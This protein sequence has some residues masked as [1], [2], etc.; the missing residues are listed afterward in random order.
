[1]PE[2]TAAKGHFN[3]RR[4]RLQYPKSLTPTKPRREDSI[5]SA[6]ETQ[7]SHPFPIVG[8]G[9]SAGGLEAFTELLTTLPANPGLAILFVLHLEPH[10][11]SHLAEILGRVTAMPIREAAENMP[12]QVDHVY[13]IPPNT[14]MALVDGRLGLTPR[15][16]E[17]GGHMPIDHLFRSVA[18]VQKAR[19]I[20]VILSGGG[21]DGTLGFQAIKAEGGITFAQDEQTARQTSMPRSAASD[22]CV[23]Y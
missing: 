1:M 15:S 8:V 2:R 23:D 22:G 18:A 17:R 10:H 13:L 12:V 11:K 4:F 19:S 7:T 21:T 5:M 20:G 3:R 14:N 6:G 9:A 16:P